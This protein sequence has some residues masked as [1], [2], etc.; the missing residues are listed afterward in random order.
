MDY[1]EALN[2]GNWYNPLKELI[3]DKRKLNRLKLIIVL[4]D[5]RFVS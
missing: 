3:A 5:R 4:I 2:P 1:M